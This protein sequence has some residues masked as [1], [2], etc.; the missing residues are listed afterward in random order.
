M[1][2]RRIAKSIGVILAA[3]LMVGAGAAEA[4]Y[5]GNHHGS[6]GYRSGPSNFEFVLEGGL[7]SP[8]GDVSDPLDFG[9][10]GKDAGTGYELGVRL[11]QFTG[12]GALAIAPSFHYV[13]FG[14]ASGVGDF[15]EGSGL[16]YEVKTSLM[17]YG[18]DFQYFMTPARGPRAGMYISGGVALLH[19]RYHDELAGYGSYDASANTPGVSLGAGLRA[20][21]FEFSAAYTYDRFSTDQMAGVAEELDYN[22][23][24][25]SVRFGV[26]F[27]G[28]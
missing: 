22:W 8:A 27:G 11:R 15:T 7:A 14:K 10:V 6:R 28:H 5:R 26:A 17:R 20:A 21:N 18:V 9:G 4:A 25:F 24:Y 19:N 1:T 23:D 3:G 12:G 13:E 16:G 2:T